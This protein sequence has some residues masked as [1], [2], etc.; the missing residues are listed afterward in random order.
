[1]GAETINFQRGEGAEITLP[2]GNHS[3]LGQGEE[4]VCIVYVSVFMHTNL[5]AGNI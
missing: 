2:V 3:K 4:C 5:I 1:M